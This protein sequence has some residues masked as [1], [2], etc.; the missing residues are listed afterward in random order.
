VEE[1]SKGRTALL[2]E[3]TRRIGKSA[4]TRDRAYLD[5]P[6]RSEDALESPPARPL[7]SWR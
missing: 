5:Y 7:A 3:G 1:D 6:L 4:V 2:V